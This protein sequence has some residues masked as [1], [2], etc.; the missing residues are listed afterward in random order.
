MLLSNVLG[1]KAAK[2]YLIHAVQ[3]EKV[4]HALMFHGRE[5]SEKLSLALAFAQYIVCENKGPADS[6]N[7]CPACLKSAKFIHPD[8]HFIFPVVKKDGKKREDTISADF[9]TEWR[10]TI[11]DHPFFSIIDWMSAINAENSQPNI[12]TKECNDIIQKLGLQS[13]ESN[14][15]VVIM[16]LPEY[17]G[18]EGNRL[19]KLIEEP[20]EN[21]Y[22]LLITE[23]L[24]SI[25]ATIISRVQMVHVKPF[26][27]EEISGLLAERS[28][29]SQDQIIQIVS[30]ADGNMSKA[31]NILDDTG[32]DYSNL[33]FEWIRLSFKSAPEVLVNFVNQLSMM[34]RESQKNFLQ[35]GLHFFR[36]YHMMLYSETKRKR[37]NNKE[38]EVAQKM[39]SIIDIAKSEQLIEIIN[40]EINHISRNANAKI[41]FMAS[42]MTIGSILKGE[43]ILVS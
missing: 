29:I 20:T 26:T 8:I 38:Y 4:P 35:Y 27:D 28:N 1:Q 19:L 42:S 13:F 9:L 25:L 31:I 36:E 15:K 41:S 3:D 40:E 10:T 24:S 43:E 37:L 11:A 14:S 12:N 23:D 5:G 18:K 22:I 7:V 39:K 6:C 32:Q 34:G 17:L 30:L 2:D 16:W 21:T 33:L